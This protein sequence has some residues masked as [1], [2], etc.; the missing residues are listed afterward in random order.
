MIEPFNYLV[1]DLQVLMVQLTPN[2][3][4]LLLLMFNQKIQKNLIQLFVKNK[5]NSM[6]LPKKNHLLMYMLG[7][8]TT[9]LT[10]LIQKISYLLSLPIEIIQILLHIL[11]QQSVLVTEL[12]LSNLQYLLLDGIVHQKNILPIYPLGTIEIMV[13]LK[14]CTIQVDTMLEKVVYQVCR[15]ST[16]WVF[17]MVM[18]KLL[19]KKLDL[20]KTR[21]SI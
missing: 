3:L 10:D 20:V 5:I 6:L 14:L 15:Q 19:L 21:L 18:I 1:K 16:I 7:K 2:I 11:Y 12:T 9:L 4:K 17:L 13:K 8:E